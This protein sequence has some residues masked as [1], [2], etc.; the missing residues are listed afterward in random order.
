MMSNGENNNKF[1]EVCM[2]D[3]MG[4]KTYDNL[5]IAFA[6]ECQARSKYDFFAAKAEEEGYIQMRNIFKETAENEK[7]HAEIWY[8]HLFGIGATKENLMSAAEGEHYEWSEM[9]KDMAIVARDEGFTE[10][11][12]Q[13][14][15]IAEIEREHEAR[16]LKLETNIDNDMVWSR[17]QEVT[18]ICTNCGHDHKGTN[19]PEICP[20]CKHA[21]GYFEI[22]AENY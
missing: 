16:Y 20:V 17:C 5:L 10:I 15:S 21:K 9:Y 3:L 8:K 12:K 4:S 18:W 19:A 1:M 6:G 7:E 2:K 14:E 13:M 22:K 11:A